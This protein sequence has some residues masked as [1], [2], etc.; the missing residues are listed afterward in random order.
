MSPSFIRFKHFILPVLLVAAGTI[1]LSALFVE[2]A[3]MPPTTNELLLR[4][5]VPPSIDSNFASDSHVDCT[6]DSSNSRCGA[7]TLIRRTTDDE[8]VREFK[9][10]V[11]HFFA[12]GDDPVHREERIKILFAQGWDIYKIMTSQEASSKLKA[13]ARV[14]RFRFSKFVSTPHFRPLMD[15]ISTKGLG[16]LLLYLGVRDPKAH[17]S[18]ITPVILHWLERGDITD[19]GNGID[20]TIQVSAVANEVV[21][22]LEDSTASEDHPD[23]MSQNGVFKPKKY[24]P[25]YRD[26]LLRQDYV[27]WPGDANV[28]KAIIDNESMA[29]TSPNRVDVRK[30]YITGILLRYSQWAKSKDK[31]KLVALK[32]HFEGQ[33][34]QKPELPPT[35]RVVLKA[36]LLALS[37]GSEAW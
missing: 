37:D 22:L 7:P 26:L 31:D 21:N 9:S 11:D 10:Q 34:T 1:P 17:D 5:A 25:T 2:A 30:A 12:L 23:P 35:V 16:I 24:L 6:L 20:G 32:K 14:A 33:I 4:D 29:A 27:P 19:I 8:T 3:P 18:A 28:D 36:Y 15:K 13:A